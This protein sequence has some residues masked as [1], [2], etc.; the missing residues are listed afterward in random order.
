MPPAPHNG[1]AAR[2]LTAMMRFGAAAALVGAAVLAAAGGGCTIKRKLG[3]V[4]RDG[5]GADAVPL[6]LQGGPAVQLG[7]GTAVCAGDLAARTFR[8]ALCSCVDLDMG[9]GFHT[10]SFDDHVGPY[11]PSGGL[12]PGGGPVGING[13]V[14]IRAD[15]E[16]EG[17][18]I[19]AGQGASSIGDAETIHGDLKTN[20]DLAVGKMVLVRRNAWIHG[21]I[22]AP[23]GVT[24]AGKLVQPPGTAAP[25]GPL[26]VGGGT[27]SAEFAITPPC[28]CG[29]GDDA[30]I[31]AAVAD[32][33]AHN[34]NAMVPLTPGALVDRHGDPDQAVSLPCGRFYV[35][36][37]SGTAPLTLF[38]QGQ[39][40]LFV[41][42]DFTAWAGLNVDLAPGAEL[43]I[44]VAGNFTLG[45]ATTWGDP[46]RAAALRVYVAG[47][48]ASMANATQF[49][50]NLYAPNATVAAQ[51]IEVFGSIVAGGLRS[52]DSVAIH[53]DRAVLTAG[54][55]CGD[56]T[57]PRVCATCSDCSGND[58]CGGGQCG[59]CDKDL[60]CCDPLVCI[61][62]SCMPLVF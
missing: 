17:T 51:N 34:D 10:D 62:G 54:A 43:D 52:T 15:A 14:S 5:G 49:A 23:D 39:A 4:H 38:V 9:A 16:V 40:A 3:E 60:D 25:S 57:G 61:S 20:G 47:S 53:F 12:S 55:S 58:G 30:A 48:V 45:S 8:F 46:L 18:L 7:T 13:Q 24:I 19:V 59:R 50:G 36:E 56:D 42:G 26:L 22:T 37:V 35:D 28:A 41:G 21:N 31:V 33:R 6:C 11:T 44:F 2:P 27:Q 29:R 1:G 32:A